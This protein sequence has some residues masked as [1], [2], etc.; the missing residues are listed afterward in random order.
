MHFL[1]AAF[2]SNQMYV[3][4]NA[5]LCSWHDLSNMYQSMIRTEQSHRWEATTADYVRLSLVLWASGLR[6]FSATGIYVPK[7]ANIQYG[8]KSKKFSCSPLFLYHNVKWMHEF[9]I[10]IICICLYFVLSDEKNL[11]AVKFL[12]RPINLSYLILSNACNLPQTWHRDDLLSAC[13]HVM[14]PKLSKR[15]TRCHWCQLS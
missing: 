14:A 13:V 2:A 11:S 10:H 8:C 1:C 12:Q 4:V 7:C 6:C 9:Y 5:K 3:F 15:P